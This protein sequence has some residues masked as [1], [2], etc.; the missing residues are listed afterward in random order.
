MKEAFKI[1]AKEPAFV[2]TGLPSETLETLIQDYYE[3]HDHLKGMVEELNY[4]VKQFG[5]ESVIKEAIKI[6]EQ[7]D[8]AELEDI[9]RTLRGF[10]KALERN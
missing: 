7:Q 2:A 3:T 1:V 9:R 4:S 10:A 8:K 5:V 6:K